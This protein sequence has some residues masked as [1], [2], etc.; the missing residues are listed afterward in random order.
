MLL[1][2]SGACQ[3]GSV[4]DALRPLTRPRLYE[5]VI[6][7]LRAHV[8]AAGLKSGDRLPPERE[9]ADRLG[10]SRASIKQAMVVLEVQGLVDVR[11]GGG[12]Y[13]VKDTLDTEPVDALVARRRRLPD[14][15]DARAALETKLAELAATRRTDDDLQA[16]GTALETMAV[17]VASGE[18]G[19]DGDRRFHAAVTAAAHSELLAD[20]MRQIADQIAESRHESLTE[21]GRP[22]SSLRQHRKIADAIRAGDPKAAARAMRSHLETVSRVRLLSWDPDAHAG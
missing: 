22:P 12:T 10:V 11:H 21:P 20:F 13:L 17:Q 3:G 18:L 9:L 19:E 1:A 4:N 5:R 14:I 8:N 7:Q 16:I 6:T 15:L 2:L